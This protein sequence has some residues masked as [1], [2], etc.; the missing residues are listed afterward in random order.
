MS[1]WQDADF[2]REY[3]RIYDATRRDQNNRRERNRKRYWENRAKESARK[4]K[5]YSENREKFLARNRRW[6]RRSREKILSWERN[7]RRDNINAR[8]SS[9]LR[10]RIYLAL[11]KNW[12]HGSTIRVLGCSIESFKIYLESQFECGMSWENYGKTEESWSLDHI[13]PCA[14]FDLSKPDHQRRCF[15]FSNIRPMWHTKNLA[16]GKRLCN[17]S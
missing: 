17:F 1:K 4:A 8:L 3:Y 5:A 11:K 10:T 9:N 2:R 7:R 6:K 15:H 12:K 16:K 13:I 14:L